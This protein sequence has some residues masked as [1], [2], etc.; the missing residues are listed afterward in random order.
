LSSAKHPRSVFCQMARTTFDDELALLI[1]TSSL[2]GKIE[3]VSQPKWSRRIYSTQTWQ[4]C[5]IMTRQDSVSNRPDDARLGGTSEQ[6]IRRAANMGLLLWSVLGAIIGYEAAR[7]RDFSLSKGAVGGFLLGPLAVF[8]F[9]MPGTVVH[10][11]QQKTCPY[12]AETVKADARI[13]MHCNAI[14]TSG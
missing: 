10:E 11:V 5:D 9:F 13:C 3:L 12:C 6:Q 4:Q 7:R 14:L 8:L 1:E 2:A